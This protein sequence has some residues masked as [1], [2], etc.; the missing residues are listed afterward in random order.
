MA[1]K[2]DEAPML[3]LAA[4]VAGGWEVLRCWHCSSRGHVQFQGDVDWEGVPVRLKTPVYEP[5]HSS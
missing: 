2:P 1:Y 3:Q 4:Q 5:V